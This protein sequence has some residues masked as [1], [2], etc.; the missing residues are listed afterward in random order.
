MEKEIEDEGVVVLG[1]LI[2]ALDTQNF[3][4]Y[5]G[6]L[7]TPPCTEGIK[8]TVLSKPMPVSAAVMKIINDEYKDNA[9][10]AAGKGN[11]RVIMPYNGRTVTFQT[12]ANLSGSGASTLIYAASAVMLASALF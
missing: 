8:W 7:T 10:F 9:K 6:S 3:W 1:D 12:P 2:E 5:N 11:N 4:S